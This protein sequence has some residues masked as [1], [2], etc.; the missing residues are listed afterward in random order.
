[1]YHPKN[2][3]SNHYVWHTLL[4]FIPRK[5]DNGP[6]LTTF[7]MTENPEIIAKGTY[8]A[9]LTINL[10]FGDDEVQQWLENLQAPYPF[11]F[12]DAE[13]LERSPKLVELIIHKKIPIGLLG[14]EGL[15]YDENPNLLEKE[16]KVYESYFKK[17]PLW[18][19]TLDEEF[20]E[21]LRKS[22]W[23]HEINALGSSIVWTSSE[24]FRNHKR[25]NCLC[26]LSYRMKR[27]RLKIL[28]H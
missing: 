26:S 16:I 19:R 6:S 8:G 2:I 20:P 5:I 11:I 13:W 17:K 18:F 28:M 7:R 27:F 25:R 15:V 9:V 1:M 3:Y 23:N 22:L 24:R 14:K 10:S 4:L 12:A 21:S